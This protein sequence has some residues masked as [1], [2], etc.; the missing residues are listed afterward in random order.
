MNQALYRAKEPL[1]EWRILSEY[2]DITLLR[3]QPNHLIEGTGGAGMLLGEN[4]TDLLMRHGSPDYRTYAH[5]EVLHY[6]FP[7]FSARFLMRQSVIKSIT[8]EI[9]KNKSVSLE[10]FTALGLHES[11]LRA[12]SISDATKK[13]AAFYKTERLRTLENA[14]DVYE[15]GIRFVFAKGRII[16][17][18][19]K[20]PE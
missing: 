18:E 14:V 10:W 16:E 9:A 4:E 15:R 11:D 5:P 17:V 7:N 13:I 8:L 1:Q 20:K 12:L 3:N 2:I 6:S 19:I